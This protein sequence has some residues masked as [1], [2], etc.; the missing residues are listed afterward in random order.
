MTMNTADDVR[1]VRAK[2][3]RGRSKSIEDDRDDREGFDDVR[4]ARKLIDVRI[5]TY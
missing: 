1:D 4:M 2:F 5:M 3:D